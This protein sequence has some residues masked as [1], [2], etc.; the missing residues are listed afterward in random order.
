MPGNLTLED[1]KKAVKSG[2]IDT[3]VAA[4]IDMQGRLMGKR[5]H[6]Q[7]FIDGGWEETHCCNYLLTVDMEMNTVQGYKSTSW[8]TGYGDYTLKPDM[9]TLRRL[10][11]L[12]LAVL[13]VFAAFPATAAPATRIVSESLH[14]N[15]EVPPPDAAAWSPQALP[16]NWNI[17]RRGIGGTVWYRFDYRIADP[18]AAVYAIYLPRVSMNG[19]VY[20]ATMNIFY[21]LRHAKLYDAVLATPMTPGDVAL[22]EIGFAV[23]R[24]FLYSVAFLLTMW[25]MGMVG[26][27]L[28]VLTLP[29]CVLI[30]FAFASREFRTV[31][32]DAAIFYFLV[33]RLLTGTGRATA[34]RSNEGEV[35]RRGLGSPFWLVLDGLALGAAAVALVGLGQAILGADIIRAEGVSRVRAFYGSPNNLAL[36]LERVLPMLLAVAVF[37]AGRRRWVSG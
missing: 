18:G 34:S 21:K 36:Y 22:G 17:S 9:K 35:H 4:G 15:S 13:A 31:F 28:V 1:L 23:L 12:V 25:A 24:G 19:A 16:D 32:L 7:F 10:P 8:Q 37:G 2:E 14:D 5:F 33:S 29:V 27:P 11:W 20:D 30:G 26:S 6:A 3:V